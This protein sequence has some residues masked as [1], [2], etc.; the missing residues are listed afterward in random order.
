MFNTIGFRQEYDNFNHYHQF[1]H[2][3]NEENMVV[4]VDSLHTS[5]RRI[6]PNVSNDGSQPYR[7]NHSH[8][9]RFHDSDDEDEGDTPSIGIDD[10]DEE[11][12]EMDS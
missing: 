10:D 3:S 7:V 12:E 8:I 9:I 2:S 4:D 6:R 1:H 11:G 5:N